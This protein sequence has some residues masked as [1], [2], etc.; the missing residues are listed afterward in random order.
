MPCSD[1]FE[2]TGS[3]SMSQD[4]QPWCD[5]MKALS[6]QHTH[7]YLYTKAVHNKCNYSNVIGVVEVAH[8]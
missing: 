7:N 5:L 3:M 4:R 2:F 6:K 8:R 1:T